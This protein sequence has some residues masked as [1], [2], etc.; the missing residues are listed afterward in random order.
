MEGAVGLED[1]Y[2]TVEEWLSLEEELDT[3]FEYLD[4]QLYDVRAMAGG[5]IPHGRACANVNR[6]LA[7]AVSAKRG[8]GCFTYTS[9][10]KVEVPRHRRYYYPDASIRCGKEEPGKAKGSY[11]NP[12]VIVE[13]VSESSYRRD[14][15]HKFRHYRSLA[16]LRDYV[17]V[18]LDEAAVTV[19][20]RERAEDNMV[21]AVYYGLDQEIRI[22]SLDVSVAA[23]DLYESVEFPKLAAVVQHPSTPQNENSGE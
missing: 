14:L 2:Y 13:V 4:G 23:C 11:V 7:N 19:Y 10:I 18:F 20:S 8:G 21:M 16:S 1:R 5:T 17:L 22:P 6:H 9:E 15:G 3:K 12:T